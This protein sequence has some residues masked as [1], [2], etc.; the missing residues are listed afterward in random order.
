MLRGA[1]AMMLAGG[2]F[3]A[4][5]DV[6][7]SRTGGVIWLRGG[8]DDAHAPA[9]G[10]ALIS[11]AVSTAS[12][13]PA[14]ALA[15]AQTDANRAIPFVGLPGTLRG[16]AAQTTR[17]APRATAMRTVTSLVT[18]AAA[19]FQMDP[20]LL[21]AVI[22]AESGFDPDALSPRG[23]VGLM[24]LM[25][26]TAGRYGAGDPHDPAFNVRAGAEHLRYL[27]NR[28]GDLPLALAAYN[29]GE[30]AVERHRMRVPPYA[31][32][33]RYVP[34]VMALYRGYQLHLPQ[35]APVSLSDQ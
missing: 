23:A 21:L 7:T 29:A 4:Q 31:E 11:R 5:A 19:D 16:L 10:A 3:A 30:G 1:V 33:R 32:T 24:Q 35:D 15:D 27:L 9:P 25:P 17:S 26:A 14:T 8:V 2:S 18:R 13:K 22:H 20:A 28:Y 34:R 12:R 6:V